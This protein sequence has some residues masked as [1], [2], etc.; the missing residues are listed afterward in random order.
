MEMAEDIVLDDD[1][2][3]SSRMDGLDLVEHGV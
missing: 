2:N 1:V 3:F